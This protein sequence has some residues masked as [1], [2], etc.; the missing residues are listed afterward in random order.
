MAYQR[1][2]LREIRVRSVGSLL[3][4]ARG[5]P[6]VECET[7]S[8]TVAFWGNTGLMRTLARCNPPRR[9]SG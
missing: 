9:Q 7:D 5:N 2:F 3:W 1:P 4:S 6:F 8:G